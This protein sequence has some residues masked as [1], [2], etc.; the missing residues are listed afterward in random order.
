MRPARRRAPGGPRDRLPDS[1]RLDDP[2]ESKPANSSAPR[3]GRRRAPSAH[4]SRACR[5]ARRVS[6]GGLHPVGLGRLAA[7]VISSP[8]GVGYP[9]QVGVDSERWKSLLPGSQEGETSEPVQS[10]GGGGAGADGAGPQQRRRRP[11]A[12]GRRS[13]AWPGVGGALSVPA[14]S[15]GEISVVVKRVEERVC[16]LPERA[17]LSGP[18]GPAAASPAASIFPFGRGNASSPSSAADA[19]A[20]PEAGGAAGTLGEETRRGR[21]GVEKPRHAAVTSPRPGRSA[22]PGRCS[23]ARCK[24]AAAPARVR[25]RGAGAGYEAE[26][27]SQRRLFPTSVSALGSCRSSTTPG[28]TRTRRA[29]TRW[30]LQEDTYDIRSGPWRAASCSRTP[31]TRCAISS[32]TRIRR[33]FRPRPR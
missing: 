14:C 13:R 21:S 8:Q 30:R 15:H 28:S 23:T 32:R 31:P 18:L 2:R 19:V 5:A 17:R 1:A 12:V 7:A 6:L 27:E 3:K 11:A 24:P 25:A 33:G 10:G 22:L 16:L 4:P 26:L 29:S 20:G 9:R